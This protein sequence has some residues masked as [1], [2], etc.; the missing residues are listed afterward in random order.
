MDVNHCRWTPSNC[1]RMRVPQLSR[2]IF[3][4]NGKS[5]LRNGGND[6]AL[7]C[8]LAVRSGRSPGTVW[9]VVNPK[10]PIL[11]FHRNA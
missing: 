6:D 7:H 9:W 8:G 1:D 11:H 5:N 10:R 3:V 4:V 2:C